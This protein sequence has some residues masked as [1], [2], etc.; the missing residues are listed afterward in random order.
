M[1]KL[2]FLIYLILVTLQ[3]FGECTICCKIRY[4]SN[5]YHPAVSESYYEGSIVGRVPIAGT[6]SAAYYQKA[7]SNTYTMNI[8]FYSGYELNEKYGNSGLDDKSIVAMINWSNGGTSFVLINKWTSTLKY[9]NEKEVKYYNA[10][11]ESI[12]KIDGYDK[13][14]RYWEIYF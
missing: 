12:P 7:W 11:G 2:L 1:R 10:T 5:I 3:S 4:L 8:K 9:I 14:G 6:G 13:D